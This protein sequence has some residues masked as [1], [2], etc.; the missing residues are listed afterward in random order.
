M[1]AWVRG[2]NSSSY[3]GGHLLTPD[4]PT[5]LFPGDLLLRFALASFGWRLGIGKRAPAQGNP[6]LGIARH[7][8]GFFFYSFTP[9]LTV[10]TSLRFPQGA[11]ILIGTETVLEDGA[12]TYH[13]PRALHHECRVFVDQAG[14]VCSCREFR[15]S[16]LGLTRRLMM[17]GL[18]DATIR[19]YYDPGTEGKVTF[20]RNPAPEYFAGDFRTA[21]MRDDPFGRYLR[22]GP[23]SGSLLITW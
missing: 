12:A 5:Q 1:I 2:T 19:F 13:F 6:V 14:G 16:E 11:P 4:D 23:L 22:L 3:Q 18:Q 17:T 8:N 20:L 9:D 10:K 7:Q 15:H 21:E